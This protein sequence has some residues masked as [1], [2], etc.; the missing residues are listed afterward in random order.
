MSAERPLLGTVFIASRWKAAMLTLASLSFV[1][2]GAFLI[3]QPSVK[4][5]A[6]GWLAILFFGACSVLWVGA[7]AVPTR[8]TIITDGFSVKQLLLP[9]KKYSWEKIDRLWALPRRIAPMVVWTY[10]ERPKLLGSAK[11][12]VG[13]PN[14]YDSGLSPVWRISAVEL[15]ATLNASRADNSPSTVE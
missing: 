5:I 3:H 4:A 2:T 8:L 12:V 6:A 9:E 11:A 14:T 10:K 7:I 13:Q 1:A 15:A